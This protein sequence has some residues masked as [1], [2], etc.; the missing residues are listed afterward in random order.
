MPDY[1]YC[2]WFGVSLRRTAQRLLEGGSRPPEALA[3][4]Q[5]VLALADWASANVGNMVEIARS[6]M[7][8]EGL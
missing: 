2:I 4:L 1:I 6:T 8:K 5:E 3:A 7:H